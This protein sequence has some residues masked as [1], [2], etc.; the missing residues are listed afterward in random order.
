V[1]LDRRIDKA[2]GLQKWW[3]SDLLHAHPVL[4][5]RG[6]FLIGKVRMDGALIGWV[7]GLDKKDML[8]QTDILELKSSYVSRVKALKIIS[9]LKSNGWIIFVY[10]KSQQ[11]KIQE[12][13]KFSQKLL[14]SKSIMDMLKTI[15]KSGIVG[16]MSP[17]EIWNSLPKMFIP[18]LAELHAEAVAVLET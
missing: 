4:K 17:D 15:S 16:K 11:K 3:L 7:V 2:T 14:R 13:I 9:D 10:E 12:H 8:V 1:D 18:K 5:K 6:K